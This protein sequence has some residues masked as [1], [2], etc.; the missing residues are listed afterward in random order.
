MWSTRAHSR[1]HHAPRSRILTGF[2]FSAGIEEPATET[3]GLAVSAHTGVSKYVPLT[4]EEI[5]AVRIGDL[6]PHASTIDLHEYSEDWP[7][8]F[9]REAA[10]VYAV[11]GEKVLMLEHVGSTSVPGLAAKPIIDMLLIVSDSSNEESYVPAME[12]A[13]YVLRIREPEWH[14]HRLFKGPDTDINLHVL[15]MGSSEI[16][17]MLGFRDW[18]R[19][20]DDD[21]LLYERTKRDLAARTWKYVQNYA[22]AKSDVVEQIVAR[23]GLSER[24]S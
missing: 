9:E 2:A 1:W 15:S 14:E 6:V 12:N 18:L 20:H 21:R 24:S 5:R 13:G 10:R 3:K 22:D 8:L 23:A 17:R 4:E 19:D 16:G 11:L 7:L